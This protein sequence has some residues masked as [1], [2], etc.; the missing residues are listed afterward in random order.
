V[1][2]EEDIL[3]IVTQSYTKAKPKKDIINEDVDM[4]EE[5]KPI[6]EKANP[7]V[8]LRELRNEENVKN[9]LEE[10]K[11]LYELPCTYFV[12][13][14]E[15]NKYGWFW[16]CPNGDGC[17]YQHKLPLDYVFK[18]KEN[19][20]VELRSFEDI[21]EE[22]RSGLT[23]G[24]PVNEDSFK[25]WKE[26]KI[27]EREDRDEEMRMQR[28]RDLKSGAAKLTGREI[29]MQQHEEQRLNLDDGDDDAIDLAALRREKEEE[30]DALDRENAKL[31]EEITTEYSNIKEPDEEEIERILSGQNGETK[32]KENNETNGKDTITEGDDGQ[33]TLIVEKVKVDVDLF[34]EE[35]DIPDFPEEDQ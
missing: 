2:N 31:I 15:E 23:G 35:E 29:I 1:N 33:K 6:V 5:K 22:R 20:V 11:A 17:P 21:I 34:N 7:F 13:A 28:T 9:G 19:I 25:A 18:S 30:E 10:F 14:V 24:T 27:R 26:K 12:D 8:D 32:G 3:S 4:E 16:E